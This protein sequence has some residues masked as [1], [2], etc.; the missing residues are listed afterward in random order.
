M[1]TYGD[2]TCPE[3]EWTLLELLG[4]FRCI[5]LGVWANPGDFCLREMSR[6]FWVGVSCS[7]RDLAVGGI[8][9]SPSTQPGTLAPGNEGGLTVRSERSWTEQGNLAVPYG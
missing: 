9:F 1:R 8:R 3:G 5:G 4:Q 2:L 6:T 7:T